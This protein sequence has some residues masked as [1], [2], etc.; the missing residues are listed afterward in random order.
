M[1]TSTA[2]WLKGGMPTS[3]AM[4]SFGRGRFGT[5]SAR[6]KNS[7]CLWI[8]AALAVAGF[9]GA[10]DLTTNEGKIYKQV[11]VT[12]VEPD[13]LSI[14]HESGTAKVLF[15]ELPEEMQRKHGYDPAKAE[16]HVRERN[17]KRAEL[18]A[19]LTAAKEKEAALKRERMMGSFAVTPETAQ[20]ISVAV[21]S[22]D[23]LKEELA[24]RW[25]MELYREDEIERKLASL[26]VKARLRVTWRRQDYDAA[27]TEHFKVIVSDAAGKVLF[28]EAPE[29]RAPK[30]VADGV[31][32]SGM[33]LNVERDL[34]EEFRVRVVDGSQGVYADFTVRGKAK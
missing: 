24:A 21:D 15:I 13:G 4:E 16:E 30:Q 9:A 7:S 12:K 32:L 27:A 2:G 1:N 22:R 26:G 6:L 10:E 33:S 17:R 25:R 23:T 29:Y 3:G 5:V 11:T 18:E 28:R 8:A 31:Y 14:M 34:G 20:G 19:I